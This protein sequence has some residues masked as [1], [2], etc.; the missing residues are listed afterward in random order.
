MLTL[1]TRDEIEAM[2]D[3]DLA[4]TLHDARCRLEDGGFDEAT[5]DR[6]WTLVAEGALVEEC[7]R[8]GL[9]TDE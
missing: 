2:D 6:H 3:A 8:R 9:P 1:L 5:D 7:R 4:D